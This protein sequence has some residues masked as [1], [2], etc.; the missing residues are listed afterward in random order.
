[1]PRI[2]PELP[3]S[4][5]ILTQ[6]L[7]ACSSR[8][9]YTKTSA[10]PLLPYHRRHL[11]NAPNTRE[12]VRYSVEHDPANRRGCRYGRA[13]RQWLTSHHPTEST[14]PASTAVTTCPR[15]R[16]STRIT[17]VCGNGTRYICS[18]TP[19]GTRGGHTKTRIAGPPRED[20]A[21]P[22]LRPHGRHHRRYAARL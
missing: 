8:T 10:S 2:G 5:S 20:D 7:L 18:T 13:G 6:P 11:Q 17:M 14:F 1:M 3:E 19:I 16:D 15:G 12:K 9:S 22:L 4:S 21:L